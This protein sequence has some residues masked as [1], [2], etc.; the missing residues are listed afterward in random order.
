M[1][2]WEKR[3]GKLLRRINHGTKRIIGVMKVTGLDY[4]QVLDRYDR[5]MRLMINAGN[6]QLFLISSG[7]VEIPVHITTT[8]AW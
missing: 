3:N 6:P 7:V 5:G 8:H 2:T 1:L 4:S